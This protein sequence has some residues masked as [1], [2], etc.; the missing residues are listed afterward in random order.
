M[1]TSQEHAKSA[2]REE[3]IAKLTDERRTLTSRL[4]ELDSS[5]GLSSAE[6]VERRQLRQR[7]FETHDHLLKLQSH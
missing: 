6:D 5:P 4:R 7:R 1:Q 2:S 3:Q